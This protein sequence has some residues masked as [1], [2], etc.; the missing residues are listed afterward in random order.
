[1]KLS[2]CH[3]PFFHSKVEPGMQGLELAEGSVVAK[4]LG[5]LVGLR[6]PAVQPWLKVGK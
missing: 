3:I 5:G 6:T 1:M 2:T 4:L